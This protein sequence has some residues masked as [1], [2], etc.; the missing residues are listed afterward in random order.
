MKTLKKLFLALGIGGWA[1]ASATGARA[2]NNTSA[3]AIQAI[4]QAAD[5]SAAVAAYA[6]G[7]AADRNNPQIYAAYVGKMV[8]LGL[9]EIAFHQAE[10]LTTMQSDNGLGWG[11]VAYVDARRGQMP[12]AI[13]AIVLA[14]QF[15]PENALVQRTAGE[16]CAWYDLKAD[17]ATLSDATRDA[18]AKIRVGLKDRAAFTEAYNTATK[19]Y[20]S[21]SSSAETS[22]APVSSIAPQ[23]QPQDYYSGIGNPYPSTSYYPDYAYADYGYY[24]SGP[25]WVAPAPWWW[26]QPVGFFGGCDFFPFTSVVVFNHHGFFHQHFHDGHDGFFAHSDHFF[27]N[28]HHGGSFFGSPARAHFAARASDAFHFHGAPAPTRTLSQMRTSQ[29]FRDSNAQRFNGSAPRTSVNRNFALR[30]PTGRTWNSPAF[31][32]RTWSGQQR[33]WTPQTFRSPAF[34]S[35]AFAAPRQSAPPTMAFRGGVPRGFVGGGGGFQGGGGR[36]FGGGHG[37]GGGHMGTRR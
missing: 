21:E 19:A 6:N 36:S 33:A 25:G 22:Q 30:M 31:A 11:V 28:T 24:D 27:H 14:G 5:P 32:Q 13:S 2:T 8:E 17:K 34:R 37:G 4:Q 10:T 15:A 12:E 20:Q 3:G 29:S 1:L 9:P 18:L 35:P 16:L 23:V 26:W 7:V